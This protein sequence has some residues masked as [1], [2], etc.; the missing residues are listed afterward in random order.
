MLRRR[1]L[2][3]KSG[4]VM[5]IVQSYSGFVNSKLLKERFAS[6]NKGGINDQENSQMPAALGL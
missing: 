4:Y 2:D 1:L 3:K 5:V 6:V